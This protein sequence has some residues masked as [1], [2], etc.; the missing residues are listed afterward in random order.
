MKDVIES[1]LSSPQPVLI[2]GTTW[3]LQPTISVTSRGVLALPLR[4]EIKRV[5]ETDSKEKKFTKNWVKG[6]REGERA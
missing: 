1:N 6:K 4:I 3:L 5:G 2:L